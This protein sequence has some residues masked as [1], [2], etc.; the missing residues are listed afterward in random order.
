MSWLRDLGWPPRDWRAFIALMASVAGAAVLT[1]VSWR[2]ITILRD[3]GR[4]YPETRLEVIKALA[5]SNYGLLG[6]IGAVLLS[7]GLAIN[8][9]SIKVTGPAGFGMDASGGD[10]PSP[11]TV[12]AAAAGAAAGATAGAAVAAPQP[13]E[14]PPQ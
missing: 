6:I 8:R 3:M 1:V 5:N 14:E 2:I 7:L 9:R 13:P 4:A 11:Q 10:E 12:A